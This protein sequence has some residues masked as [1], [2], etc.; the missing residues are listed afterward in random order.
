MDIA[1]V[2]CLRHQV[3]SY[4]C[5]VFNFN[6]F[7]SVAHPPLHQCWMAVLL[8]SVFHHKSPHNRALIVADQL[9][10]FNLIYQNGRILPLCP[11]WVAAFYAITVAYT[12]IWY[13][14]AKLG[15]VREHL[16]L[17]LHLVTYT[18][19]SICGVLISSYAPRSLCDFY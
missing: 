11:T 8:T 18:A 5:L 1:F 17:P 4:A 16:H 10:V 3:L 12:G 7:T 14:P 15:R 19:T 9:A 2:V 13:Y 6:V